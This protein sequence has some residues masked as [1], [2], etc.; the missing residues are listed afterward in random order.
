MRTVVPREAVAAVES[1]LE[2]A[3]WDAPPP[4]GAFE[5]G[6]AW[7][8]EAHWEEAPG[9]ALLR[10]L[11]ER[12]LAPA[13]CPPFEI[14]YLPPRDWLGHA[15]S[16]LSPVE[17]GRFY[18]H[19]AHDAHRVP[20]GTI[21]LQIEA[22]PAFGTGHHG[23][24]RGCLLAF[25]RLLKRT[26]PD[27]RPARVLDVGCGSGVLAIAAAKVLKKRAIASD[28]DPTSAR[29]TAGNAR[30]NGVGPLV[31]ALAVADLDHP[32]IRENGP[33]DLVFANILAR[34]LIGLAG[35]I[36]GALAPGGRAILSGLLRHQER[37]VVH[38]YES[39]YLTVEARLP[40]GEWMTLVMRKPG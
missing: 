5:E 10:D 4:I 26:G 11:L 28:I 30:G 31:T 20:P 34:P 29:V 40:L 2:E 22:G 16:L 21:P 1:A 24:T 32:V 36:A 6:T 19:G 27:R 12:A 14:Q 35:P 38:A 9:P 39:R 13:P 23:T 33:Y 25:D 37:A 17:A 8:V 3:F 7:R 18:V 15:L